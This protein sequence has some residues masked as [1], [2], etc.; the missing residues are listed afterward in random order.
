V[1]GRRAVQLVRHP[2][3]GHQLGRLHLPGARSL[4]VDPRRRNGDDHGPAGA[5]ADPDPATHAHAGADTNSLPD[6]NAGSDPNADAGSDPHAEPNPDPQA[7]P[8]TDASAERD[9]DPTPYPDGNAARNADAHRHA[10][11][12][13]RPPG[14]T[15]GDTNVDGRRNPPGRPTPGWWLERVGDAGDEPGHWSRRS[16]IG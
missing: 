9:P 3:D 10:S 11:R 7:N 16:V 2:A 13:A 15:A 5:N 1:E 8:D 14:V 6:T 4:L 12:H